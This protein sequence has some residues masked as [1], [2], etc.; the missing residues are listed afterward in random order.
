VTISKLNGKIL[1]IQSSALTEQS[2]DT[3]ERCFFALQCNITLTVSWYLDSLLCSRNCSINEAD[4]ALCNPE[5][6]RSCNLSVAQY[7][8]RPDNTKQ[9]V[10]SK[11]LNF[12]LQF[13][14]HYGSWKHLIGSNPAT[15]WKNYT[16]PLTKRGQRCIIHYWKEV[17]EKGTK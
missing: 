15:S 13:Y 10:H 4:T 12:P 1:Y 11:L 8:S 5:P 3:V 14:S 16:L 17:G 7:L 2:R 6:E 9:T